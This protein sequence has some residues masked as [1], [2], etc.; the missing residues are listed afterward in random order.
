[1]IEHDDIHKSM[2]VHSIK[3]PID[4]VVLLFSHSPEWDLGY[5]SAK[6]LSL[7]TYIYLINTTY[8]CND[9]KRERTAEVV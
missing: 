4:P 7:H 8:I 3:R 6:P 5:H 1:M 2:Q 9:N